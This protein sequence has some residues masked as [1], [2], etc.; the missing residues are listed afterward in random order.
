[1]LISVGFAQKSELWQ[2]VVPISHRSCQVM[3][4]MSRVCVGGISHD[5]VSKLWQ[6]LCSPNKSGP[7]ISQP[8]LMLCSA[9][10]PM[11]SENL[12]GAA[13]VP[14]AQSRGGIRTY[15]TI[16]ACLC[17]RLSPKSKWHVPPPDHGF[18]CCSCSQLCQSL[19]RPK[20][21]QSLTNTGREGLRDGSIYRRC[22]AK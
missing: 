12:S 21:G 9:G 7:G 1:M 20:M 19:C 4:A 14:N 2:H 3:V 22:P 15:G 10:F 13:N 8:I 11:P 6:L 18:A 16:F 17:H 5:S